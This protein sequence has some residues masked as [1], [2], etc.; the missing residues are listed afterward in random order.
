MLFD[1][2]E[3]VINR[4]IGWSEYGFYLIQI[5][6][7]IRAAGTVEIAGL[8]KK[9]NID[10]IR[11]IEEQARKVLPLLGKKKK[12]WI[13]FRPTLPDSLPVIGVSK[14]NKRVVYAFGHQHLG[15]TLGAVTGKIVES[16]V[17]NQQP[18]INIK[19]FSPNRFK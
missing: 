3:Q 6:E 10:R 2:Q 8:Y 9:P 13:G 19:P 5:E 14:K 15:W 12:D 11:M 4:P 17:K 1:N 18:N 7:G 16:L